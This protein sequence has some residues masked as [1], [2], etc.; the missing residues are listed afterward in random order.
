MKKAELLFRK[1]V[2][3]DVPFICKT[4]LSAIGALDFEKDNDRD[5]RRAVDALNDIVL[6][7]DSLY[8]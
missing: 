4:V 5:C 6:M 8:S 1:A 7:E 3:S 2:V